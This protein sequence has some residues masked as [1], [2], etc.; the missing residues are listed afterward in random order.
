MMRPFCLFVSSLVFLFWAPSVLSREPVSGLPSRRINR[1][2][3]LTS[4]SADL[5]MTLDPEVLVGI[6]AT[7]L[8]KS[9]PR[10]DGITPVSSGRS[11]PSVE[12]IVAL[13]PDLVIGAEGFHSKILSG[14]NSLG[15]AS[16]PLKIN[17]WDR[18]EN[19]AY[20]LRKMLSSSDVL[21]QKLAATC[22]PTSVDRQVST[23]RPRVL[24]LVGVSPKMSPSS[25]SWSGS[26]LARH[27]LINASEGISG[28]SEFSGYVTMSRERMLSVAADTVIAVNPSGG[29]ESYRASIQ[30]LFPKLKR[31]DFIQMD[32]YGFINPG[33][34]KSIA[35]ACQRLRSL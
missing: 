8:T 19:A 22:P 16:L 21:D 35:L 3:A 12:A 4:L 33:S 24:V 23:Q 34:L 30:Q 15:I 9:D 2:V 18:L 27:N 20:S 6:P 31:Q 7:S 14:L 29:V 5:V 25:E 10:F 13:N 28:G 32:Y 11:Q 17:R 26:L 1:V